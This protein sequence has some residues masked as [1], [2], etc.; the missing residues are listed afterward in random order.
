MYVVGTGQT[1]REVIPALGHG[2][3]IRDQRLTNYEM[4][5]FLTQF[6]MLIMNLVSKFEKKHT[7]QLKNE[8]F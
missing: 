8:N 3:I 7:L 5:Y 2:I 4:I 1:Q 6:F